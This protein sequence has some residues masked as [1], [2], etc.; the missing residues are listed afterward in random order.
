MFL[1]DEAAV[2]ESGNIDG[3]DPLIATL[4][5][6]SDTEHSIESKL[7]LDANGNVPT[8]FALRIRRTPKGKKPHGLV[9]TTEQSSAHKQVL[10]AESKHWVSDATRE[11]LVF[12]RGSPASG[13][14]VGR[15]GFHNWLADEHK[16]VV[17]KD[18]VHNETMQVRRTSK[19]HNEQAFMQGNKQYFWRRARGSGREDHKGHF[20]HHLECVNEAEQV[21]AIYTSESEPS[22]SGGADSM[23]ARF[24]VTAPDLKPEFV[25]LLLMTF[26]AVYVKLQRRILEHNQSG[27]GGFVRRALY[28]VRS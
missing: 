19:V 7:P 15:L 24:E 4:E 9:F 5:S 25:E 21:Y 16:P 18:T 26:V 3:F 17:V 20:R 6:D 8:G 10:F 13:R 27:A 22:T 1:K 23:V 11:E 14:A 28:G 12:Y 2:D